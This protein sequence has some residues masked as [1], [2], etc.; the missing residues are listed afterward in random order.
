MLRAKKPSSLGEVTLIEHTLQVLEAWRAF[1]SSRLGH[2]WKRFWGFT[3]SDWSRYCL[4]TEVACLL[5]DIGKANEDFQEAVVAK[6]LFRQAYRHEHLSAFILIEL[7]EWLQGNAD[8]DTPAILGAVLGHHLRVDRNEGPHP[9]GSPNQEGAARVR[10]LLSDPEVRGI[11]GY[12]SSI[13]SLEPAPEIGLPEWDYRDRTC[14]GI[15]QNGWGTVIKFEKE[16]RRDANRKIFSIALRLGLIVADSLGS[17]LVRKGANIQ[18][19]VLEKTR[20]ALEPDEIRRTVIDEIVSGISGFVGL[21]PMQKQAEQAPKR[22]LM[23]G[24]CNSGKTLGSYLWFNSMVSK[25][26][27]GRVITLYPTCATSTEGFLGYATKAKHSALVHSRS[28]Y[29]IQEM[30]ANPDEKCNVK[31]LSEE[32]R[33]LF[34]L[35]YWGST[36]F[37]ATADQFLGSLYYNYGSIC[38]LPLIAD[39]AVVIDEIHTWDD[40]MFEALLKFLDT[41]PRV[42]ILCMTATLQQGRIQD[43]RERGF[44]LIESNDGES[45]RLAELPKY[46]VNQSTMEECFTHTLNAYNKGLKTLWIANTVGECLQV[47]EVLKQYGVGN[48]LVYH[49]RFINRDRKDRHRD[50]INAF[51]AG[52]SPVIVVTTQVS[53]VSFDLQ[54]VQVLATELCPIPSFIQRL[55]RSNRHLLPGYVAP[56]Y[57][58]SREGLNDKCPYLP[59][60]KE[61]F[62]SL[63]AFLAQLGDAPI[64][65]KFL[66]EVFE[67]VGKIGPLVKDPYTP[68]LSGAFFPQVGDFRDIAEVTTSCVLEEHLTQ[69]LDG[70]PS[71]LELVK[72]KK[73]IDAYVVPV[74]R[75]E[76]L[77]TRPKLP[78]HIKVAPIGSYRYDPKTGYQKAQ[79][80]S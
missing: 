19:W 15:F 40:R 26:S 8:L 24:A 58:Y 50:A 57:S 9:W 3:E 65:Q 41:F 47:A 34:S 11:L 12:I 64:S 31:G 22:S 23:L 28:D 42:P 10:L 59:Y 79:N 21:R 14:E 62:D 27:I 33:R 38:L 2:A 6:R 4:N 20:V 13:A 55:G 60:K 25:H 63:R 67:R 5:H 66:V 69:G 78:R 53:E 1:R 44:T 77:E 54:E 56:V 71:V 68:A 30:L 51:K 80:A 70:N 75:S 52:T 17:G 72:A 29:E 18:D 36:V 35:A 37:S 32:D 48:V 49:S 45:A 76:V 39:A 16:L 46:Q 74:L 7:Q 61:D 43:L 73:P